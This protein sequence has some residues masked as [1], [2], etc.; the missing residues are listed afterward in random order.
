[1]GRKGG[2]MQLAN[3]WEGETGKGAFCKKAVTY[4]K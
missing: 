3:E 2:N 1:M 4:I